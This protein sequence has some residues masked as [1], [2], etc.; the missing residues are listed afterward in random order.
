MT[1]GRC[2]DK[3]NVKLF[4][5]AFN[6]IHAFVAWLVAILGVPEPVTFV[7]RL[8]QLQLSHL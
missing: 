4:A 2:G 3:L 5:K 1:F 7:S 8:S 6:L